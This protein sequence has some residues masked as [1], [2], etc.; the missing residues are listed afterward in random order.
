M[1]EYINNSPNVNGGKKMKK[2]ILKTLIVIMAILF[3]ASLS[4]F[5]LAACND[6][7]TGKPSDQ[8][9]Q[10][11]EKEPYKFDYDFSHYK[12]VVFG[13]E[14][15]WD[16]RTSLSGPQ[17]LYYHAYETTEKTKFVLT[18]AFLPRATSEYVISVHG[19]AQSEAMTS[20]PFSA[21]QK[22]FLNG[23]E[24]AGEVIRGNFWANLKL[25]YKKTYVFN[26]YFDIRED[27]FQDP[28]WETINPSSNS[29]QLSMAI[30]PQVYDKDT[31]IIVAPYDTYAFN[32]TA[33]PYNV[34]VE[35]SI[36]DD[37]S[38]DGYDG[39]GP[40]LNFIDS[41]SLQYSKTKTIT[42]C[43]KFDDH[44]V[45]VTNNYG[46]PLKLNLKETVIPT[47]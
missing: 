7:N 14:I 29:S 2:N 33:E 41:Y 40:S 8:D 26:A 44:I 3:I 42:S 10:P 24:L 31:E 28:Y 4:I 45:V 27:I 30:T 43:D 46:V 21:L 35:L 19:P 6:N 12:E 22:V 23:E 36:I 25:E 9:T 37:E 13:E 34:Q 32:Y 5:M 38:V 15:S 39:H 20:H 47:N 17:D 18:W 1:S 16:Y 11:S